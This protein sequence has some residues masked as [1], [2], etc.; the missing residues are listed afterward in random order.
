MEFLLKKTTYF[1]KL[2]TS[3]AKNKKITIMII[4]TE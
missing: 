2:V 1:K 4:C 3:I